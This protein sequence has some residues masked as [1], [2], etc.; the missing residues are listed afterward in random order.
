[1]V[2]AAGMHW[3]GVDGGNSGGGVTV[4]GGLGCKGSLHPE[5]CEWVRIEAAKWEGPD[6]RGVVVEEGVGVTVNF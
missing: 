2:S 1:M 3:A 6:V 4:G 5:R